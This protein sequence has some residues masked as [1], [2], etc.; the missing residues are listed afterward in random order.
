MFHRKAG[1]SPETELPDKDFSRASNYEKDFKPL[2]TVQD[3]RFGKVA[4]LK[5]PTTGDQIIA[6]EQKFHSKKDATTAILAARARIA[7]QSPYNLR[8]LDYAAEKHSQLCATTYVVKQFWE[9]PSQDLRK[10]LHDRQKSGQHFTEA[11]LSHVLYRLVKANPAGHHGDIN[12]FNVVFDRATGSARLIDR[13]DEAPSA[14]RTINVQKARVATNQPLYQSPTMYSNLKRNNLKFEF[15]GGKEDAFALGLTLLELGNLR[16]VA[17][18]YNAQ[19]KE[20]DAQALAQHRESFRAR[21]GGHPNHFIWSVVERLTHVDPVHRLGLAELH[22]TLMPEA[23]FRSRFPLTGASILPPLM[24]ATVSAATIVGR[25]APMQMV[26]TLVSSQPSHS[27]HV[28][29]PIGPTASN[30]TLIHQHASMIDQCVTDSQLVA[31][32]QPVMHEFRTGGSVICPRVIHNYH[33]NDINIHPPRT[34]PGPNL[35]LYAPPQEMYVSSAPGP[36]VSQYRPS[37][38]ITVAPVTYCAE[39]ARMIYESRAQPYSSL[40]SSSYL[41]NAASMETAAHHATHMRTSYRA[42]PAGGVTTVVESGPQ[43]LPRGG[44]FK[45]VRSYHD[46]VFATNVGNY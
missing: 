46:P 32:I 28:P 23:E 21:Y 30:V 37:E 36:L 3:P 44:S 26:E 22:A 25:E 6:R 45:L 39:P 38:M 14:Q 1:K 42:L 15:D 2:R 11:E 27:L 31:Q 41:N 9:L 35:N 13:W 8:L 20:V 29:S 5:S 19:K 12:P 10:E 16:P 7:A 4:V 17:D 33:G 24:T 18:I 40:M 34:Y 43:G